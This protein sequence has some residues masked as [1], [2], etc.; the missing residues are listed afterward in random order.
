MAEHAE[1]SLK[2]ATLSVVSAAQELGGEVHLLVAGAH[3]SGVV[4]AARKL[5]GVSKVLT[6]ET[7]LLE[8]CLLAEPM[9]QLLSAI[10]QRKCYTHILAPATSF[11]KNLLPRAA[12][13]LDTSPLND[14]SRIVDRHTFV[15]CGPLISTAAQWTSSSCT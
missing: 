14:V 11:G 5:Q 1:G 15:R 4:E 9:A 2:Q 6:A 8:K 7:N 10:A 12:A 3:L 13:L